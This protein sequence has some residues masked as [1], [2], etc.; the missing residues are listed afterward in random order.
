VADDSPWIIR[1]AASE[2][3][4]FMADMLVE[5]VNWSPEWKKMSRNR[6]LLSPRTARYIAG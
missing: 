3:G 5:A 6:V 2:D 4:D 1:R